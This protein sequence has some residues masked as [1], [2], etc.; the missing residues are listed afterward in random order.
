[1]ELKIDLPVSR[2][3]GFEA[4]RKMTTT[5]EIDK[6]LALTGGDHGL[7]RDL[8]GAFREEYPLMVA[9]LATGLQDEDIE[10]VRTSARSIRGAADTV[11]ATD[12]HTTATQIEAEAEADNL[13]SA[14]GLLE[15]L[16]VE[17]AHF[18]AVTE[19]H[20]GDKKK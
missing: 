7:V 2:T 4:G 11:G 1:M 8:V 5:F 15:R 17:L 12:I 16:R 3:G 18:D 20:F 6:A 14:V 13:S 10:R 19:D 9:Q